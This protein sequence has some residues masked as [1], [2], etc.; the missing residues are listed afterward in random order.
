MVSQLKKGMKAQALLL[1]NE[2]FTLAMR[3]SSDIKGVAD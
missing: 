1:F 3:T 2:D